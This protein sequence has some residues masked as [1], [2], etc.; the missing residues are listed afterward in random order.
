MDYQIREAKRE[1]CF[2]I[3]KIT[4]I[5]WQE[6]YPGIVSEAFLTKLKLN[7]KDRIQKA[8]AEFNSTPYQELV[9]EVNGK[10]V[11]FVR[12]GSSS[13]PKIPQC[14]EIFALYIL[15]D[16]QGY[17]YGKK[18]VNA[19]LAKLK[20]QGFKAVI[21][22]CLAENKSNDFYKHIGGKLIDTQYYTGTGENIL[23]NLYLFNSSN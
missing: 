17:G 13:Y 8:Y 3:P 16:Y 10:V 21:I 2:I 14:G 9:L 5:C 22:G 15:K 19:A 20:N 4:T 23:E 12:Y 7:E 18:L 6:T 1:D 11:G